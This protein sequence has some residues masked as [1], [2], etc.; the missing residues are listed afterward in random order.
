M[1]PPAATVIVAGEMV[2]VQAKAMG[3]NREKARNR[4]AHENIRMV[5]L[6][7]FLSECGTAAELFCKT[8]YK[9]T[10]RGTKSNLFLWKTQG[11]CVIS[12]TY[13]VH[14]HLLFD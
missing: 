3:T 14:Y 7:E 4:T 1:V 10:V 8:T 11:W 6:L 2:M 5:I 12:S 13:E 9:S